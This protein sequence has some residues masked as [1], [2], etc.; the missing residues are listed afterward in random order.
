MC[1]TQQGW[2]H[3]EAQKAQADAHMRPRRLM[4]CGDPLDLVGHLLLARHSHVAR[5]H[6]HR[7]GCLRL[8]Y[9]HY[10]CDLGSA[11]CFQECLNVQ[12][13]RNGWQEVCKNTINMI[14]VHEKQPGR[15][16]HLHSWQ[17]THMQTRLSHRQGQQP[18][19]REECRLG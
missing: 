5:S 2:T 12:C 14:L 15:D 8:E 16:T 18:M 13:H 3:F 11:L 9:V 19:R 4:H 10:T 7:A 17:G 6:M 1:V